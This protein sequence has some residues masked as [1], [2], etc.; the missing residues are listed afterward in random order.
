MAD[1]F[2]PLPLEW[3]VKAVDDVQNVLAYKREEDPNMWTSERQKKA[4][5]RVIAE[6]DDYWSLGGL[7]DG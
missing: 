3:H 5:S 2:W 1:R 7:A 6:L 4:T